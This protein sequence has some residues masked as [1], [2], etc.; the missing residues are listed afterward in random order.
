MIL[1]FHPLFDADQ[2]RLCAGRDPGKEELAAIRRADAVILPQGCRESLYDMAC[3]TCPH[4]FP[5]YDARFAYPE[6][7]GQARL[8]Q[9]TNVPHPRTE[10]FADGR[11]SE[12]RYRHLLKNL[13]LQLPFVFKLDWGGEGKTV[14]LIRSLVDLEQQLDKI[15]L[16]KKFG[17][18][19][20]LLQELIPTRGRSLRIVVINKRMVA[21][22]RVQDNSTTFFTNVSKGAKI[23]F[24]TDPG[25][26]EAAIAAAQNFCRK[27]G[28]NLAGFDFLFSESDLETNVIKPLFLEINYFF[29][30]KGLGGS[31]AFYRTLNQEIDS[32]IAEVT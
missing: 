17:T 26:K 3:K 25:L 32:W 24:D 28:I 13:P 29:G 5:N 15:R 21:Y 19:G 7:I 9:E 10:V 2:N 23:D 22:W 31:D 16:D 18:S 11:L 12:H 1:S 27:T 8:F 6:K 14:F 4:V 30:R 20:F